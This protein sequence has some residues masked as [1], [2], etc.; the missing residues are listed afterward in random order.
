MDGRGYSYGVNQH[1]H[2]EDA[3]QIMA[4]CASVAMDRMT[5]D[6][7]IER[8]HME[9]SETEAML[10][11]TILQPLGEGPRAECNSTSAPEPPCADAVDRLIRR[12]DGAQRR[13]IAL[14]E[15]LQFAARAIQGLGVG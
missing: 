7:A 13:L 12:V 4:G 2:P 14:R 6:A 15:R 1:L 5:L 3:K 9:I 11:H 10:A 8:L